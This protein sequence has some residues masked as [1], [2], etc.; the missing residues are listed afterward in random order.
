MTISKLVKTAKT[1]PIAKLLTKYGR[2]ETDVI[3]IYSE[4]IQH[5]YPS[6]FMSLLTMAEYVNH[7]LP[8]MDEECNI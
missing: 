3:Q 7:V 4:Y 1:E 2:K 5:S 6:S 8:D